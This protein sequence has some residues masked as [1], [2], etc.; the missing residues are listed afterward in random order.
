M[1]KRS[2]KKEILQKAESMI[3]DAAADAHI[4]YNVKFTFHGYDADVQT[5]YVFEE[6]E[7]PNSVE[8]HMVATLQDE[9]QTLNKRY[10]VGIMYQEK[11]PFPDLEQ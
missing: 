5:F 11:D 6:A 1:G 4:L 10:R 8:H 3:E 9:L 2:L 7:S